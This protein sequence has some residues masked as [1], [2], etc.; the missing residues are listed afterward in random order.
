MQKGEIIPQ[1][2]FPN[3]E[4]TLVLLD[5]NFNVFGQTYEFDKQKKLQL[6]YKLMKPDESPTW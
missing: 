4:H 5:E 1:I 6:Q 2:N 3:E